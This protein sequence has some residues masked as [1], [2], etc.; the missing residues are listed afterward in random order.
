MKQGIRASKD[1][2]CTIQTKL[3]RFLLAYRN[4]EHGLTK[5]SPARVFMSRPLR[6]RLDMLRPSMT[7]S[8]RGKLHD[9]MQKCKSK[10]RTFEVD[11]KVFVRDFR[12]RE[13]N[14]IKWTPGVITKKLGPL[15]YEVKVGDKLKWCRHLDQIKSRFSDQ[16]TDVDNVTDDII[17]ELIDNHMEMSDGEVECNEGQGL[18]K[19]PNPS[20]AISEPD[21]H[22]R[23]STRVRKTPTRYI[24]EC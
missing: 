19:I 13:P 24:E 15:R 3:S 2:G 8:V 16:G 20:V 1:D 22:V 9:Q 4:A 23:R 5:Q 6:S 12:E 21:I 18:E 10:I 11:D 7:D 14:K 17:D